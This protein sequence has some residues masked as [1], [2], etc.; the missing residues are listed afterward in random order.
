MRD[1]LTRVERVILFELHRLEGERPGRSVASA[2]LYGRVVEHIDI[3]PETMQLV[4]ARLGA[5]R[6]GVAR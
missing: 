2:Q 4:L 3:T 5:R 6:D 1:G